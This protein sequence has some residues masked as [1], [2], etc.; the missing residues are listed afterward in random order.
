MSTAILT[1]ET[2][3][4]VVVAGGGMAGATL[5]L[6]LAAQN[7]GLRVAV[8]E[9]I[10][11]GPGQNQT[12][13]HDMPGRAYQP[14][15]DAR[16][17]AMAW[18]TRQ[19]YE[20]LALWDALAAQATPIK[21]I[22]VSER[23]RFGGSRMDATEHNQPAL[24]YVVDNAW[25]GTVLQNALERREGIDWVCPARVVEVQ[26][27]PDYARLRLERED[28]DS[29]G[30]SSGGSEFIT[31]GLLVMADGG[32]SGLREALGF[33]VER[34]DYGQVAL[35]ANVSSSAAH[36][37][38]AFE[39]FTATGPIALLPRGG[40]SRAG[41]AC[42]LVWTLSPG[43][44]Q[45]VRELPEPQFLAALQEAFGWR[46]GRFTKVG[47]RYTYP[48]GLQRVRQPVRPHVVLVGNAAHTL[49]P[50]AGQGFN[51]AIRGLMRL[52]QELGQAK[53]RGERP[54]NLSVLNRFWD[55]QRDD[56]DTLVRASGAL[57]GLFSGQ[58]PAP[59]ELGRSAGLM[60][61]DLLPPMR[62]WFTR[63]A[64]G[65]GRGSPVETAQ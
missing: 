15:Y 29:A 47:Q 16:A 64:M 48:L 3:Y 26:N 22:H 24:G 58:P 6:A 46:L 49:H 50:V 11:I 33:Q 65:L 20:R 59:V 30:G 62:R 41:H 45:R 23:K 10:A 18:G 60:A 1:P 44:A 12:Q 25:T 36:D 43:E 39:R 56:V 63:Q 61:L 37:F 35:I 4:D 54:G 52:A 51:L 40:A 53:T 32:R 38:E 7:A 14:S 9:A 5:A 8:V 42:G 34:Q 27:Y 57:V 31:T 28:G 13:N 19:C 2:D 21:R 17:T 55:A